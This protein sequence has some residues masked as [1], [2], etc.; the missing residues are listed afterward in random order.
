MKIAAIAAL[1]AVAAAAVDPFAAI[2]EHWDQLTSLIEEDLPILQVADAKLYAAATSIIGGTKITQAFNTDLVQQAG[3]TGVTADGKPLPTGDSKPT[4]A[5][6]SPEPTAAQSSSAE[7]KP[8]AAPTSAPSSSAEDKP[9]AAPTSAPKPSAS[10]TSELGSEADE[11]S[12]ASGAKPSTAPK[13]SSGA[14]KSG[15]DKSSATD[16][17][18]E[19]NGAAK[20]LAGSFG[21]AIVAAAAFF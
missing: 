11:E 7:D 5:E 19:S 13:S 9:S 6:S 16:K 3:I 12:A 21:A 18:T 10:H 14:D 1:A 8:S 15:A 4:A 17:K 20:V 2:S